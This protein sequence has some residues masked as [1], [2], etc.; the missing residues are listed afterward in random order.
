[1]AY[2]FKKVFFYIRHA[3]KRVFYF[4]VLKQ[5]IDGVIVVNTGKNSC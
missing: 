2:S 5:D 3:N 1:M 4:P